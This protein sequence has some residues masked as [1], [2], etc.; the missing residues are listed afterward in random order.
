MELKMKYQY[1]NFVY[2]YIVEEKN[3]KKYIQKLLKNNI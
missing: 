2:P 1:T 3:Y